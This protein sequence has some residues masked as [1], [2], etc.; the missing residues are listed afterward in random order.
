MKQ[1]ILAF[2]LIMFF[3]FFNMGCGSSTTD[4]VLKSVTNS[5]AF[6]NMTDVT[7]LLY[8][9]GKLETQIFPDTSYWMDVPEGHHTYAALDKTSRAEIKN[10]NFSQGD[11]I[12]ITR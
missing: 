9:D 1:K 12:N 4:E 10:G 7:V 3:S 6:T 2:I 11:K 8:I 5:N